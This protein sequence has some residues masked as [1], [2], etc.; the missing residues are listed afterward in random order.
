MAHSSTTLSIN[1]LIP[2][3]SQE[4]DKATIQSVLDLSNCI[5]DTGS[6]PPTHHSSLDAWCQRLAKPSAILVYGSSTTSSNSDSP[7]L[8]GFIFVNPR[9][10][11]PALPYPTLHIW[12]AGVSENARGTG[13]F[14]AMMDVVE[15]HARDKAFE[16]LSV[17]TFPERFGKMFAILQKQGWEVRAWMEDGKKVLMMKRV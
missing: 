9:S 16:A 4:D 6:S 15:R 3:A 7:S 12:L 11:D 17:C 10:K 1:K 14:A 2:S 5:F 8:T 13:V